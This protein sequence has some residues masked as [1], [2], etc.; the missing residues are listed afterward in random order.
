M[1]ATMMMMMIMIMIVEVG[2]FIVLAGGSGWRQRMKFVYCGAAQQTKQ[3]QHQ[4]IIICCWW[5]WK[6]CNHLD[7][8]SSHGSLVT[9]GQHVFS[10]PGRLLVGI[11]TTTYPF[12]PCFKILFK[13][14]SISA[15]LCG[16]LWFGM[17]PVWVLMLY[18][19]SVWDV[20]MFDVFQY[21]MFWC[22]CWQGGYQELSL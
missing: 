15:F 20:L 14:I 1:I 21:E 4:M 6:W 3:R 8:I 9:C 13:T 18:I 16:M 17:F 7:H 2:F 22:C 12:F 10:W 11:A 5:R 19:S